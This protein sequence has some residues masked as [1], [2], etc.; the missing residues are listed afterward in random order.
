MRVCVLG[1]VFGTIGG[2]GKGADIIGVTFLGHHGVVHHGRLR[3]EVLTS[4][5][6]VLLCLNR[7]GESQQTEKNRK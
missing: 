6:W 2:S 3:L 4:H 7:A 1:A 5:A